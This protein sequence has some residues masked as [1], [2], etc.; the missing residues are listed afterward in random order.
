MKSHERMGPRAA[1]EHSSTGRWVKALFW[2]CRLQ[3]PLRL[4]LLLVPLVF[5]DP[6]RILAQGGPPII[7]QQPQSQTVVAG[8]NVTFSVV[9]SSLTALTYQWRFNDGDIPGATDSSYSLWNVQVTNAGAYRVFVQNLVGSAL[10]SNAILTVNAP[11]LTPYRPAGW[12]ERSWS[13]QRLE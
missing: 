11:N 12:S 2:P 7:V 13:P 1:G 10:S 6:A 4:A 3:S 5:A 8:T 9:V